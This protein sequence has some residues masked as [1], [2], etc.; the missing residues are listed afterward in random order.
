MKIYIFLTHI[1]GIQLVFNLKG[2]AIN[3]FQFWDFVTL[4]LSHMHT[5]VQFL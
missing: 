4:L 5:Y 2:I 1:R 3:N